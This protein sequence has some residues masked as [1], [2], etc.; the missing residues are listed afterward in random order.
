MKLRLLDIL[1]CPSCGGRFAARD[2]ETERRVY[3]PEW[4]HILREYCESR[5]HE[6]G[7]SPGAMFESFQTE[8]MSGELRCEPCG[9]AY[10]I[11][12]G[13]PV[14]LSPDLRTTRGVMGRVDPTRDDRITSFMDDRKVVESTDA[15]RFD[16]IQKA[17]QSNYGYEWKAFS[18]EHGKWEAVYKDYYVFEEDGF[19]RGKLGL[20]AGCGQGRFA[21][22]PAR[23]GAEMV[24]VDLSNAIEAAYEKSRSVPLFHAVQGDLF[25]LPLRNGV[26]DFAQTL[27]VVHITPDPESA[28]RGVSDKV[29]EGGKIWLYVYPSF[30]DENKL[31]YHLLKLITQVRRVTVRIPSNILYYLLYPALGLVLVLLYYP[32]TALWHVG[33]RKLATLPPY[34]YEQYRGRPLRDIH[35]NLFD[36]FG[37][38]VE[39]RYHR[40]EMEDWMRRAGF[41]KYRLYFKDGWTVGA[42]K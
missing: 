41:A 42:V 1:V 12:S 37:N 34:N 13:I 8:I 9:A 10:P 2:L 25:R 28:L 24:G 31:R 23:K 5:A 6:E 22:V 11:E 16:E 3:D 39:R 7:L 15:R 26:F 14:M 38:P 19:F 29:K 21:L 4:Q 27:G 33:L 35:M 20:D 32:S 17:N 36:R 40:S 18:Y 30:R